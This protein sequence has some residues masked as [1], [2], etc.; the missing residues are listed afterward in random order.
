MTARKPAECGTQ[1]G[2]GKHIRDKTKVCPGCAEAH[3]VYQRNWQRALRARELKAMAAAAAARE[4]T[5][6]KA[7]REA[8]VLDA[9]FAGDLVLG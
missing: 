6:G 3:R 8:P 4:R 2:Y 9:H 1:G 5:R 7:R